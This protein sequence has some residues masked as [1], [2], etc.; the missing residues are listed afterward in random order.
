MQ[1][2]TI[3]QTGEKRYEAMPLYVRIGLNLLYVGHLKEKLL[4]TGILDKILEHET[5]RQGRYFDS[6]KSV[7]Q[8]PSFIKTYNIPTD[9][10]LTPDIASF[11][12][13]NEFFYRRLKPDALANVHTTCAMA[14]PAPQQH[15]V[16]SSSDCR[17]IVFPTVD[18]ATKFWI[19]GRHFTLGNL[20][21][22]DELAQRFAGASLAIFRLAP[23][24][25][26]RFHA[27]ITARCTGCRSIPG[28]YYTVNPLAVN[29]SI[30]VLTENARAVLTFTTVP[31]DSAT[32][33]LSKPYDFI[34]VPVGAML[35][36][37]IRLTGGQPGVQTRKGDELG[38]FA[39]GGS[40]VVAVFPPGGSMRFDEDLL[41]NSA[42]GLETLVRMGESIGVLA[43]DG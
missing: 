15:T 17:L 32:D 20:L 22:D 29:T 41:R 34:L 12:T 4:E 40:T 14:D 30:D 10:M 23:Q 28:K 5:I 35:V 27:P 7:K 2:D 1:A 3:D 43:S 8:I 31:D 38:Y 16:V 37:S 18:E 13:F 39:F 21:Q 9:E 26:H 33:K 11:G 25:Y 19:K 24:D 6:P 36:G 42:S